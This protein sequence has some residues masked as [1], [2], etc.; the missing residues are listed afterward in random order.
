MDFRSCPLQKI[1][2][3]FIKDFI[4][5]GGMWVSKEWSYLFGK[6]YF[7]WGGAGQKSQKIDVFMNGP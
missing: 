4:H 5:E 1:K 6:R 2:C 7:E 3:T